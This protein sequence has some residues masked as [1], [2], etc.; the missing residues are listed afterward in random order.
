M[1]AAVYSYMAA[2]YYNIMYLSQCMIFDLR[3]LHDFMVIP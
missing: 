1:D 2:T 3:K